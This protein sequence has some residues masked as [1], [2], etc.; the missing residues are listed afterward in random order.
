MLLADSQGP[1]QQ[2]RMPP[3]VKEEVEL[4]Y[5]SR[6][7]FATSGILSFTAVP[8]F[9]FQDRRLKNAKLAI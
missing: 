3:V 8:T 1:Q 7:S 4:E 6:S 9:A 5:S 2:G